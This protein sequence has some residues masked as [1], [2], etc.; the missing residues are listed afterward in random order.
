MQQSPPRF[1]RQTRVHDDKC[2]RQSEVHIDNYVQAR[3]LNRDVPTL[4]QRTQ[5]LNLMGNDIGVYPESMDGFRQSID[6]HS[7]LINGTQ[8]G[9][10]TSEKTKACTQTRT[11]IGVP[12]VGSG[13]STL[14]SPEIKSQLMMGEL[15]NQR[16]TCSGLSGISIDRMTPLV[17][18]I[19]ENIQNPSHLIQTWPRGGQ[20][21]NVVVRNIDYMKTCGYR[22]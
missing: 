17:P 13:Q 18:H 8:G 16:K 5:Y 15:T 10:I 4:S 6:A 1:Y 2:Q 9:V 14:R 3:Q 20:M 21:T 12:F 22:S 19:A 11:F 7:G